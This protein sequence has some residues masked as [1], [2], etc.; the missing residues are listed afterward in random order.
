MSDFTGCLH[1]G[2]L[3]EIYLLFFLST[4]SLWLLKSTGNLLE[5]YLEPLTV[6]FISWE[7]GNQREIQIVVPFLYQPLV[8]F[9]YQHMQDIISKLLEKIVVPKTMKNILKLSDMMDLDLND[10]KFLKDVKSIPLNFATKEAV[11]HSKISNQ[12]EMLCDVM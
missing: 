6:K 7:N 3:L 10:N 4:G 11:K 1:T 8:P 2:K 12:E 5:F 9:L